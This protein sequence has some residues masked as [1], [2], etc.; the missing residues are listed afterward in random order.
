MGREKK[1]G[2]TVA[3]GRCELTWLWPLPRSPAADAP[4][5]SGGRKGGTE[6]WSA[7]CASAVAS[8]LSGPDAQGHLQRPR[9]PAPEMCPE[10]GPP[11]APPTRPRPVLLPLS[12]LSP[13][14][15]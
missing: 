4:T 8:R 12:D 5:G 2:D 9:R 7:G 15:P 14:M 6:G 11:L 3:W 10:Q 1:G 13:S